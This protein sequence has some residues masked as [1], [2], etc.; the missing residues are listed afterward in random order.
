MWPSAKTFDWYVDRRRSLSGSL[1]RFSALVVA[2][3]KV[4]AGVAIG[5]I[6]I[7]A[8]VTGY[9]AWSSRRETKAAGLLFQAVKQLTS[10]RGAAEDAA[11]QEEAVGLL[12]EL[13]ARYPGTAAAAEATL[14]LGTLYY[15]IAEFDEARNTYQGYLT[16]HPRGR[17]AFAAGMGVGDTYVSQEKYDKAIESYS[18]LIDQFPQDPLL[19]EA[20]LNLARTYVKINKGQEAIRLYQKVA[21]GYPNTGWDRSARSQLRKLAPR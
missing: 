4:A 7:L 18:R 3:P 16:R 21:E 20:L 10:S 8:V 19:P 14:R 6:A 12:R 9:L 1:R 5:G 13:T 17:V 15:T 2:K 11:K